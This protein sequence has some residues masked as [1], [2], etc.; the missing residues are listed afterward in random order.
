MAHCELVE[1]KKLLDELLRAGML[2]PF[3]ALYGAPVLFQKKQDGSLRMCVDYRALK[4]VVIKNKYLVPNVADLF[5]RLS[6]ALYFINNKYLVPNVA[7]LFYRFYAGLSAGHAFGAAM[8][9]AYFESLSI[10]ERVRKM[11]CSLALPNSVSVCNNQTVW[12]SVVGIL[13]N[14]KKRTVMCDCQEKGWLAG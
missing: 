12:L 9:T 13:G 5:Y 11:A 6:K 2:Q 7:D 14:A 4:K 8:N 10:K 3:K 1:L